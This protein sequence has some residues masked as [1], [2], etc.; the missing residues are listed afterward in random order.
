MSGPINLPNIPVKT[1]NLS[2][3]IERVRHSIKSGG[4]VSSVKRDAE[5]KETCCE[6]ESLFINYLLNNLK[7][8]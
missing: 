7:F 4:N 3:E 1:I 6:L 5:L 8:S 2:N